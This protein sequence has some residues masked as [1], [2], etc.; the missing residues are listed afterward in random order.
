[1]KNIG[2]VLHDECVGCEACRS[3][4]PKDAITMSKD[5]KGFWHPVIDSASCVNCGKCAEACPVL[6]HSFNETEQSVYALALKDEEQKYHSSSGGAFYWLATSVLS[7]NGIVYGA[8][9]DK[10]TQSV[11]HIRVDSE[12]ELR[13]LQSSKYVQSRIGDCYLLVKLDLEA[14]KLVLFSGTPCQIAGLYCFLG[15]RYENL[16][17]CDI[18]CYGAPSPWVFEKYLRETAGGDALSVNMREKRFGW[19]GY[20]MYIET[21]EQ[22]YRQEKTKDIYQ[23]GF[24]TNLFYRDCCFNCQFRKTARV[25][26]FTLGDFWLF[27]ES[28]QRDS[29]RNN[30]TGISFFM[31]NNGR[32]ASFFDELDKSQIIYEKRSLDE[33]VRNFGFGKKMEVAKERE[34]FFKALESKPYSEA[35]AP[36]IDPN[37]NSRVSFARRIYRSLKKNYYVRKLLHSFGIAV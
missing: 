31:I 26:D 15:K 30:D 33:N 9:F 18:L 25:G 23:L 34:D 19:V 22:S 37:R 29:I 20:S 3:V 12:A 17:T 6:K 4:C 8:A 10:G 21:G 14:G 1:M 28:F 24:Q 13:L 11:K 7:R 36:Y 32:A 5:Q 35:I 27:K 16:Y 2:S